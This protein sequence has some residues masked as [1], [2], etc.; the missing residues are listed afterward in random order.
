MKK[1]IA[2]M[3]LL[4]GGMFAAPRINVGVRFGAP[5]PVVA[6][7]RPACP[8]PGYTWVDGYYQTNGMFVAGYW[9][10]PVAPVVVRPTPVL[11]RVDRDDHY[12]HARVE[13]RGR[14]DRDDHFRR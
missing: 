3:M 13:T 12:V 8:G 1:T 6:V 9:A 14:T 4:A 10:P 11:R 5:A 7:P 2:V